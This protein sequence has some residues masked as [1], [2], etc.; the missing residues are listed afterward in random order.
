MSEIITIDY[1]KGDHEQG[2]LPPD[3]YFSAI[4]AN[5]DMTSSDWYTEFELN[6]NN[7]ISL[8]Y[9]DR[10]ILPKYVGSSDTNTYNNIRHAI[11]YILYSR[12][13][14]FANLYLSRTVEFNPTWN[15]DGKTVTNRILNQTGTDTNARTGNDAVASTG[16][17]VTTDQQT[18]YDTSF[19]DTDKSTLT[20]GKT[21]TTT[22]NN[23]NTETRNLKD[24][25]DITVTRQGN[26]GT[27]TTVY[28]LNEFEGWWTKFDLW[29]YITQTIANQISYMIY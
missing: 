3:T 21:D 14:E 11:A 13:R 20:H 16:S 12:Q 22:Y 7:L 28:M 8:Y 27:T 10:V 19:Q 2:L 17:N 26:I 29:K 6:F 18:T 4:D 9:G 1:I 5:Q 24:K 15:V 23:T 25:E